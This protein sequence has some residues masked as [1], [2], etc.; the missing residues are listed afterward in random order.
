[1]ELCSPVSSKWIWEDVGRLSDLCLLGGTMATRTVG[2][3]RLEHRHDSAV[4]GNGTLFGA[5]VGQLAVQTCQTHLAWSQPPRLTGV[6]DEL[7]NS[8]LQGRGSGVCCLLFLDTLA[9]GLVF[10]P[11]LE[12]V[13]RHFVW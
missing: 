10:W 3:W 9:L 13:L 1:M 4:D 12:G 8:R 11:G 2:W 7:E 5:C 6:A